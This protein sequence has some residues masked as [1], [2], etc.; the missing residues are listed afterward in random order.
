MGIDRIALPDGEVAEAINRLP[1][2]PIHWTTIE[3]QPKPDEQITKDWKQRW[4][5]FSQCS[6]PPEDDLIEQFRRTVFDRASEVMGADMAK[7]EKFTTSVKDGIDIRDTVRN[8]YLIFRESGPEAWDRLEPQ[9][10]QLSD[11]QLNDLLNETH[12]VVPEKKSLIKAW[13]SFAEAME[14]SDWGG[15]LEVTAFKNFS[16]G[17]LQRLGLAQAM[18]HDP[19][20]LM[21]DEPTDGLD[22]RARAEMRQI[23]HRLRELGVTIFLNSHLLQ[24]VEL[25]CD[26]VAILNLGQLKYCGPVDTIG[27]EVANENQQINAEVD[28]CAPIEEIESALQGRTFKHVKPP[29]KTIASIDIAFSYQGEVDEFVDEMRKRQISILRLLP[30]RISLEDAFLKLIEDL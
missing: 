24:E 11:A 26:S 10:F 17:M 8:A 14:A 20:L 18:L 23:I 25:I 1:G 16:K 15:L 9:G 21:L 12:A 4:N 13:G 3:I 6:W 30:R 28:L 19:K 2:P 22:P 7:T 29:T 5:P 27:Q